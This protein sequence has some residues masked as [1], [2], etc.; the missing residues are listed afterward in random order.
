MQV[1]SIPKSHMHILREK[2]ENTS[3]WGQQVLYIAISKQLSKIF[4]EKEEDSGMCVL[5]VNCNL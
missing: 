3:R 5:P 2:K 1:D 4:V